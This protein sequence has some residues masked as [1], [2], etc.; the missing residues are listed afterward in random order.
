MAHAQA[1]LLRRDRWVR[2]HPNATS[3]WAAALRAPAPEADV[4]AIV[5]R[6]RADGDAALRALTREFDGADLEELF[7]PTSELERAGEAL[8]ADLRQA[9]EASA[10]AIRRYHADQRAALRAE[11]RVRTRPGVTAWRRWVPIQRAGGYVP[12]GRARYP[13]SVLMLG[14][15]AALAGVEELI[16]ATPPAPDGSV[17]PAVL[18]AAS[19]TGVARVL[20]VGGA[21]AI[22]ALAYGTESVE[23]AD[24]IFGAGNAWVT[25]GKRLVAADVAIDLPAGPS[26]CLIVADATGDPA[27]IA[28]DL[29]AQA[30]HGPDSLA[31]LVT[32]VSSLPDAVEAEIMRQAATLATGEA[33]LANLRDWGRCIL[34][35]GAAEAAQAAEAIAPEHLSL[36]CRDAE[37]LAGRVRNAGAVFIGPWSA[38]AAGDYATGT[39]HV[40]PTGGAARAYG[41][42]GVESF[43][44]WIEVQRV[45]ADG[46]RRLAPIVERIAAAEG[47]PAH[48]ASVSLRVARPAAR[49]PGADDPVELLRRPGPVIAYPAEPSDDDVAASLGLPRERILRFD[50]N[51]LG[52]GP[53]P[54]A[55]AGLAAYDATHLT[56]YGD[57][58]FRLLRAALGERLGVPPGRILPGAGADELIRLVATA[59][60]AE[61]DAALI[62]TP[63]FGMFA[64]ETRLTGARVVDLPRRDPGHRQPVAELRLAAAQEAVRLVWLCSPNNPTGDRYPIAE[65]REL[66]TD[67]PAVVL[68]DEVYLEFAEADSGEAPG[69]GSAVRLQDELPN[70]IVLRSLS[71][72]YGAAAAR[73]GYLV[74]PEPLA[75]RF[76]AMRLPLALAEPSEAVALGVLADEEA[77]SARRRQMVAE[78]RRLAEAIEELGCR[79]LPSVTNFVAFRPPDGPAL[80]RALTLRGMVLR[81]YADGPLAGW[82]RA[83]VR[84]REQTGALIDTL[85]ELLA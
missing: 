59:I 85:R 37:E 10:D 42:L 9:L 32:D 66:A 77:A 48:A 44:R 28:A 21:Q 56:E 24:R 63:S 15:P 81:E 35:D 60:L 83:S 49:V 18:H 54:G 7:V 11:R 6:V 27:L 64:V 23:R 39:N 5:A 8:P 3:H 40:L 52:G 58:A 62:P 73:V 43:G 1:T 84:D 17:D 70:V 26:E 30:E 22:A 61:G 25:A 20:R 13:S 68:V 33:A 69:S 45:T 46:I 36:Q 16:I 4:A 50:L 75:A 72:S 76:D 78:R 71:K 67:L 53:L 12:G 14:I 65:I 51:T 19:M 41:G 55:L 31:V 29:L 82:L 34:V 2:M 57:M 47:L 38:V 79:T 74:L 80:A